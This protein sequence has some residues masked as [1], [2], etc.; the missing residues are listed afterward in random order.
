[1]Q[2]TCTCN[3]QND[4]VACMYVYNYYDGVIIVELF[5]FPMQ[6]GATP[7]SK[8]NIQ[9]THTFKNIAEHDGCC[10]CIYEPACIS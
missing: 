7:V 8:Y 2:C 3:I 9:H 5:V 10:V 6:D 4:M 1:M